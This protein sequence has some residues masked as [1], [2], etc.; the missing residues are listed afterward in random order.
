[1]LMKLG[2]ESGHKEADNRVRCEAAR[3]NPCVLDAGR[4]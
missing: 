2:E 4:S 1:M 3:R